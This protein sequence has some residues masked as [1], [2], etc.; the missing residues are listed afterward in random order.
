MLSRTFGA[1]TKITYNVNNVPELVKNNLACF[2][3]AFLITVLLSV[4]SSSWRLKVFSV[5]FFFKSD[6]TYRAIRV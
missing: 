4:F 6:D 5:L 2:E 1:K 3:G